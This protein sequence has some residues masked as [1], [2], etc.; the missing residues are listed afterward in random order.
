M[1]GVGNDVP[2]RHGLH[3]RLRGVLPIPAGS[4]DTGTYPGLS[5]SAFGRDHAQ[6]STSVARGPR[7]GRLKQVASTPQRVVLRPSRPPP[8]H[9]APPSR[10][11]ERPNF[12]KEPRPHLVRHAGRGVY[13]TW[14]RHVIV[15]SDPKHS[16]GGT[17]AHCARLTTPDAAR[18][19]VILVVRVV[20]ARSRPPVGG[21]GYRWLRSDPG[22]RRQAR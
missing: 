10:A 8:A 17:P 4:G 15:I 5:A 3:R 11:G 22:D 7:F 14:Y 21:G 12:V 19:A 6:Y 18:S 13:T 1:S 20:E 9:N 2:V 16:C